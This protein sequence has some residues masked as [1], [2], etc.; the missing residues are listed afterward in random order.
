MEFEFL[1]QSFEQ[2]LNTKINMQQHECIN[3]VA[4]PMMDFNLRKIL[5]SMFS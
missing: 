3:N 2:S 5:F 4:T 1:L